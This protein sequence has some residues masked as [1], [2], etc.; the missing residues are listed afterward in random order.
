MN[1]SPVVVLV[2]LFVLTAGGIG[3]AVF[4][5]GPNTGDSTHGPRFVEVAEDKGIEYRAISG[6]PATRGG[7]VYVTDFNNDGW[8]DLLVIGGTAR[9]SE[10]GAW[11]GSHPAL[12]E[13]IEGRFKR[14]KPEFP[15]E[16]L[17]DEEWIG[18]ISFDYDND[19]WEDLV[20]MPENGKPTF[21]ANENGSFEIRDVGLDITLHEPVGATVADYD[22][23]GFLDLFIYQ[24]GN[25]KNT[26]PIGYRNTN[27]SV[28]ND[29]GN[30]N[31]LFDGNGS[32][33]TRVRQSGIKGERWTLAASFV[34]FTGDGYPDIHVANDYN[35]DYLYINQG[36]GTFTQIEMG[37]E[38][39]RNA[40]SSEV[41][42]VNMDDR[43]DIFVTNIYLNASNIAGSELGM[44]YL[45]YRLGKRLA[46]NN[47]LINRGDGRFVDSASEYTVA[48]S[49]WGWASAAVDLDND[50]D[51]DIVHTTKEL[52]RS[53]SERS[54]HYTRYPA[55]YERRGDQFRLLNAT[56][57]GLEPSNGLGLVHF[58]FDRDGDQDLVVS[59]FNGRF[60]LYEN[61]A[62]AGNW[63]QVHVRG[64]HGS[65]HAIGARVYVTVDNT[66]RI[67]ALNVKAD[68]Q[69]QDTRGLHFGMQD[70]ESIARLRVVWAD[71]TER[72]YED[73]DVNQRIVISPNGIEIASPS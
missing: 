9:R 53:L 55:V 26:T 49:G 19:G 34:D 1:R 72:V 38:T 40:M 37:E 24:N 3:G 60:L 5:L 73:I 32:S 67:Q 18:V 57:I 31:L 69:S 21:L 51:T 42:D 22:R 11:L 50:M 43:L 39:N 68:F 15:A 6:M 33:F 36:D 46:G 35:N 61:T 54:K 7:A 48:Q 20:L 28:E 52:P 25:W 8:P 4:V 58:D 23:D 65:K 62:K 71:G 30:P 29:N 59:T 45:K 13:N 56:R 66:T 12:F 16:E 14:V 27:S 44:S 41:F 63:L 64:L 17:E 2:A 47:L 70:Y 10:S